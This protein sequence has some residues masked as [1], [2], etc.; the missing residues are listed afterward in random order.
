MTHY[1]CV[2]IGNKN[3]FKLHQLKL[4]LPSAPSTL[5]HEQDLFKSLLAFIYERLQTSRFLRLCFPLTFSKIEF[6][7]VSEMSMRV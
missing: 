3:S 5:E 1:I 2:S 7:E 4:Q 6:W